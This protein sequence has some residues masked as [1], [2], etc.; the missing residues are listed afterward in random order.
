MPVEAMRHGSLGADRPTGA[1]QHPQDLPAVPCADG[2]GHLGEGQGERSHRHG[3]EQ[4]PH[5]A[6]RRRSHEGRELAPLVAMR[7]QRPRALATRP[8][9]AA[10]NGREPHAMWSCRPQRSPLPW[11]G[12][13]QGLHDAREGFWKAPCAMGAAL[14]WR[15]RGPFEGHPTRRRSSQPR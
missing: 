2:L 14:T 9:A 8:P 12:R 15:G 11:V 4:Q 6:P 10:Q 5:R 13:L 7:H 1:I 3:G